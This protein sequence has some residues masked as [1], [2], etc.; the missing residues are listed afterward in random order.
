MK[1]KSIP[2]IM[3]NL[4]KIIPFIVAFLFMV[5]SANA[6]RYFLSDNDS[7]VRGCNGT[8]EIKIDTEG[9]SVMAGD[10]TISVNSSELVVNQLTI[11]SILSMQMFHQIT[12][13]T[14]KLSGARLPTSGTFNGTGT[15]G[16]ISFLPDENASSGSFN[17][18]NDLLIENNLV[19][20]N[21]SNI[22]TAAVNKT[23]NFAY[24]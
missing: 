20:D 15:F 7:L 11:G 2:I 17:F 22:L 18:S 3:K 21:I 5:P 6:A 14:L 9:Y 8:I 1:S 16:Y 23:Y 12:G 24:R 13:D 4:I 19:D 10:S